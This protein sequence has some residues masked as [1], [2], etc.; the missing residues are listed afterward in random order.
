V[1]DDLRQ[2]TATYK[3]IELV[4][5]E[6]S[7]PEGLNEHYVLRYW[8]RWYRELEMSRHVAQSSLPTLT[9]AMGY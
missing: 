8:Q 2:E 9:I 4:K 3:E 5:A 7:N 1:Y 6:V